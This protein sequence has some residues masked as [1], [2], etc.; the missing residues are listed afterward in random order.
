MQQAKEILRLFTRDYG[1]KDNPI[2][3]ARNE[4]VAR[5]FGIRHDEN[6]TR[7]LS[8]LAREGGTGPLSNEFLH[9]YVMDVHAN[10]GP[11]QSPAKIFNTPIGKTLTQFQ[12]WGANT[13]RMMTREY[14]MP[15]TRA[16][17][18]GDPAE[19]GYHTLRSLGYLAAGAGTGALFTGIIN[20]I[21][22][23]DPKDPT[24]AE[25]GKQFMKGDYA[26]AL[27]WALTKMYGSLM[28]SG[29]TGLFGD[30]A[31]MIQEH[32]GKSPS[33][34][35]RDPTHGPTLGVMEPFM[36]LLSNIKDEGIGTAMKD[37]K[38]WNDFAS[39]LSSTYRVGKNIAL[40]TANSAGIKIPWSEEYGAQNN[41]NFARSRIDMY[42]AQNPVLQQAAK[43]GLYPQQPRTPFDPTGDRIVNGLLSGHGEEVNSAIREWLSSVPVEERKAEYNRIKAKI[44]DNS[45]LKV[46]GST[47]PEAVM[48][49][50]DWAR[51]NLPEGEARRIYSLAQTYAKT[52]L[53][54]GL[55]DRSKGM[56]QLATLDYDKAR[57]VPQASAQVQARQQAAAAA[58]G[59]AVMAELIRRDRV[60]RQLQA[61]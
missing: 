34:I 37:P 57:A 41:R 49:F 3:R 51:G 50:L 20:A 30:Y 36:S 29:F 11:S 16:I 14:L 17:Q 58:Q 6:P 7:T 56:H 15:L 8:A 23:R 46:G 1:V 19:I 22:R 5:R 2:T 48:G 44:N 28:M 42:A 38:I 54:T 26:Q 53:E 27:Q 40:G 45:P 31:S 9:Q 4:F 55:E 61:R 43:K 25:I 13:S 32:V 52:A 12:R 60:A 10:Y 39:R 35:L 21:Y 18:S 24:F 59:R 47:K 33:G